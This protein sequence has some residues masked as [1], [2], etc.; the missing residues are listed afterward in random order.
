R[1]TAGGCGRPRR[2]RGPRRRAPARPT[3]SRPTRPAPPARAPRRKA[4]GRAPRG[5]SRAPHRQSARAGVA[6]AAAE[7]RLD[8]QELVVLAD[9]I[10]AARRAGLDLAGAG[11]D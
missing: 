5:A 1:A 11:G 2:W 3:G 6:G 10:G 4:P 8:A 9:A 7:L